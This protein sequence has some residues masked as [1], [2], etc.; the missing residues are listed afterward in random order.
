QPDQDHQRTAVVVLSVDIF[1]HF[2][3]PYWCRTVP[4]LDAPLETSV[5]RPLTTSRSADYGG[6]LLIRFL[7]AVAFLNSGVIPECR[8]RE[9]EGKQKKF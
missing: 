1:L 5:A 9:Q 7:C 6:K 3:P 8:W 4:A 2:H